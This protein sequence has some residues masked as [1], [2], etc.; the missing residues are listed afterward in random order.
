MCSC[1]R[2]A[3]AISCAVTLDAALRRLTACSACRDD[4][5]RQGLHRQPTV[6]DP[7]A[8]LA[9][10]LRVLPEHPLGC[11]WEPE[12][13][14]LTVAAPAAD[15]CRYSLTWVAEAAVW[16]ARWAPGSCGSILASPPCLPQRVHR[17]HPVSMRNQHHAVVQQRLLPKHA[18]PLLT[19]HASH[20]RITRWTALVVNVC[21]SSAAE[22]GAGER[23][24]KGGGVNIG[25]HLQPLDW[26]TSLFAIRTGSGLP[27]D[28]RRT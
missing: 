19:R 4:N 27:V 7:S 11:R 24:G 21:H 17:W 13:A 10:P 5:K 15:A 14:E 3:S 22:G 2:I 26:Q 1:W 9:V 16:R 23:G 20:A 12:I 18:N 8:P 25:A 28:V 6:T